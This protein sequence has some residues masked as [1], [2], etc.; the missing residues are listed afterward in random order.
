MISIQQCFYS[1]KECVDPPARSA[2]H[3]AHRFLPRQSTAEDELFDV[4]AE[5][6]RKAARAT[7]PQTQTA[8]QNSMIVFADEFELFRDQPVSYV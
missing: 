1:A 3:R 5:T 2:I 7:L 4:D 6:A 8:H